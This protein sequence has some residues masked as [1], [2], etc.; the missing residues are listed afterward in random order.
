MLW[1]C[2]RKNV[3]LS[4]GA[5]CVQSTH[6]LKHDGNLVGRVLSPLGLHG[7]LGGKWFMTCVALRDPSAGLSRRRWRRIAPP[8]RLQLKS[9]FYYTARPTISR[10]SRWL[11]LDQHDEAIVIGD[12]DFHFDRPF[13]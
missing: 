6:E 13:L 12:D 8:L 11:L 5:D 9:S 7:Q 3:S 2:G 4:V 1:Y 10:A